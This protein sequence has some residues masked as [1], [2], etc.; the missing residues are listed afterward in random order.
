MGGRGRFAGV[1]GRVLRPCVAG[2]LAA[3][4]V[5]LVHPA[6]HGHSMREVRTGHWTPQTGLASFYGRT[7]AR[8]RRTASGA[9]FNP[10]ALTAAHAWLPFGTK[11][12]VTVEQTGRSVV[13]TID[14]RPGNRRRIIDLSFGAARRLGILRQGVVEVR[15][16][17][18]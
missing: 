5:G 10:N 1:I 3:G 8:F 18:A 15:L 17:P 4:L 11:V 12:R 7:R 2:I 13:V 16:A 14:D 6:A 9:R